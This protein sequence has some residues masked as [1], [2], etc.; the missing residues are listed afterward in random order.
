MTVDRYVG[1]L[2]DPEQKEEEEEEERMKNEEKA[3][4]E[5]VFVSSGLFASLNHHQ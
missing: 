3:E 2:E 4:E 1:L 5:E